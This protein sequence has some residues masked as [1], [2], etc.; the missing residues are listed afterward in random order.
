MLFFAGRTVVKQR[1]L[2]APGVFLLD[3]VSRFGAFGDMAHLYFT[4]PF[5]QEGFESSNFGD[6]RVSWLTAIPVSTP[7]MNFARANSTDALEQRFV[8]KDVDWKNLK[9]RSAV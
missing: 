7:E 1:W 6:R 5:A 3:A 9:R 8:E 4:T 2:C